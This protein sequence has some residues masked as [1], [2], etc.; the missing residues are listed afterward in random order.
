MRSRSLTVLPVLAAAL[1][2]T[3]CAVAPGPAPGKPAP[4]LPADS[5]AYDKL[6]TVTTRPN[7]F[8]DSCTQFERNPALLAALG[9]TSQPTFDPNVKACDINSADGLLVVH[10][11]AADS[12]QPDPWQSA[13]MSESG[14]SSHFRREILLGRYYA[15]TSAGMNGCSLIVNTGSAEPLAFDTFHQGGADDSSIDG[16]RRAADKYCPPL[17]KMA[18]D[19]FAAVDPGGGSLVR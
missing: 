1:A 17:R 13:W 12:R 18:G 2:L 10:T 8:P 3:G 6:P 16:Y 15:V 5:I 7:V 4:T 11:D 9:A 14:L 19:Y